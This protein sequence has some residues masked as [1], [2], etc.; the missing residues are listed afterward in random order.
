MQGSR[1]IEK[2]LTYEPNEEKEH[3]WVSIHS[4]RQA[5]AS[6]A[7]S[8]I[9]GAAPAPPPHYVLAAGDR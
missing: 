2:V 3:A 8:I 9:A 7:A 4:H 6:H 1:R 5:S